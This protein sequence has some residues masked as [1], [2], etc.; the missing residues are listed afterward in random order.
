MAEMAV[1]RA[2]F[3]VQEITK[4]NWGG[5]EVLLRPQYDPDLPEDQKFAKATPSGELRMDVDNP[6][7]LE[8]LS[9]GR[10]FYLDFVPVPT[11]G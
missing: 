1:I 11:D 6:K 9:M 10:V 8:E 4:N 3:M 2:K 5:T 7:A